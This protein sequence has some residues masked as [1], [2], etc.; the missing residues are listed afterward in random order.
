M[1]KSRRPGSTSLHGCRRK[2][3][4]GQHIATSLQDEAGAK[5]HNCRVSQVQNS[6]SLH[7]CG[8]KHLQGSTKSLHSCRA[9]RLHGN[10]SLHSGRAL[11][12]WDKLVA[13]HNIATQ[14]QAKAVARQHLV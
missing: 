1:E 12:R 2:Q 13:T 3:I 10:T 6:K 14:L 7:G 8:T 9:K 4:A 11:H 5:Q